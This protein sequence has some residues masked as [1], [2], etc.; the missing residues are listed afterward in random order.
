MQSAADLLL[1][2]KQ[3]QQDLLQAG[4]RP[5][6]EPSFNP[7]VALW[8]MKCKTCD[9]SFPLHAIPCRMQEQISLSQVKN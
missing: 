8:Q 7:Q 1:Q 3:Q 2:Q 4:M 5:L 6:L 9:I